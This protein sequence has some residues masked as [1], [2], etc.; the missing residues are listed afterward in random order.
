MLIVGGGVAPGVA[1]TAER[2]GRDQLTTKGGVEIS[3][4]LQGGPTEITR[5]A[6]T[7]ETVGYVDT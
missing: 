7:V 4:F 2:N 3:P 6:A 1:D 5:E